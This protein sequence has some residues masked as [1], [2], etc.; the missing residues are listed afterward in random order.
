LLLTAVLLWIWIER[1]PRLLQTHRAA[2]DPY[3]PPAVLTAA[4]PPRAAAAG[5]WDRQMDR[6]TDDVPLH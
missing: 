4:N 3:H 2:I 6:Q 1:Q 5:E